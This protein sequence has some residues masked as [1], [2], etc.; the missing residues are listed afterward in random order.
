DLNPK[1]R[2]EIV[3]AGGIGVWSNPLPLIS[4]LDG[5]LLG[6]WEAL[7]EE[8]IPLFLEFA[9][10]KE[11]L[12]GRLAAFEF[13]Y[14]R[15]L[16]E[17]PIKIRKSYQLKDPLLSKI[18]SEKSQFKESYL[19]E[20]SKGCGRACRFC[21][22][23]YIYRPPRQ[24]SQEALFEKIKEIPPHSKVGLIGLEFVD[25]VEVIRLAKELLKRDIT[26]TF[27]SLRLDALTDE[28]ISLLNKTKSIALAQET[29][30]EKLKKVI[31]KNINNELVLKILEKFKKTNDKKIKFYFMFGL[32]CES[33]EDFKENIK[34]IRELLKIK[35]PFKLV[36][37]FSPFVPKPH[38]PFQWAD[39]D[40]ALL[41]RKKEI[42]I[43]ELG[44]VCEIK[45]ESLKLALQQVLIAR[46]DENLGESLLSLAQ[47]EPLNR[48]LKSIEDLD[49]IFRPPK[50]K[51][52]SFPWERF[53]THVSRDFLFSEWQRALEEKT[54][55]S[56]KLNSCRLCSAC[57]ILKN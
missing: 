25:K 37:N 2:E 38:T 40:L 41:K 28:F 49:A 3:L 33:I 46:G 26:L 34:F 12:L 8:V 16:A 35:W 20:V 52:R 54:T 50:E 22:A 14:S 48:V 1:N 27:S 36:F 45:I 19:L 43:K 32:P 39:F 15:D 4:F 10:K 6:E 44:R 53:D 29:A 56:C 21:L 31:N 51:E 57:N 11:E 5:V 55:P 23:G 47:G 42:L 17:K 7:E 30:S 13:F 18:T 24:Y 9:F